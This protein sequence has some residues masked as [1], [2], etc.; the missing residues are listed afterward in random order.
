[1]Q[2]IYTHVFEKHLKNY[3]QMVFVMGPRQVGKTT[4]G[5][6]IKNTWGEGRDYNWDK[7]IDR[8]K[9]LKGP[10]II[11]EEMKLHELKKSEPI[12]LFDE[13]H[14]YEDWKNFLKGFY[15]GYSDQVKIIVTGSARLN[16][17]KR[18]GDSLMGRYFYYHFHPLSVAEIIDPTNISEEEI[19][20]IPRPINEDDFQSLLKFGGFPDPFLR[21]DMRFSRRWKNLRFQ[22]LFEEDIRD[23]TRIQEIAQMEVLAELLRHR[24]GELIS[25]ESLASQVKV[26]GPTI[27]NWLDVFKSFYYCFEVRPYSKNIARSLIKEPK[28]YLWDWSLCEKG[29]AYV[30]NFVASHLLKAINFWNDTGLGEY[31]LNF[32]RDKDQRE[33]D[34][35]IIKDDQPVKRGAF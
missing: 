28:Y 19:H 13:I 15:D 23:Q 18:G 25:Y 34:F 3:R 7:R 17:F 20:S 10:E 9:I 22:Q 24:I 16:V 2:R 35:I 4:T 33:V 32:L 12:V 31:R 8:T 1:M 27:R 21:R 14:K 5:L 29:G 11:A 26:T 6:V 30:E